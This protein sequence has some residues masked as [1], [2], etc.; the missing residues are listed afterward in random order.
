MTYLIRN[1]IKCVAITEFLEGLIHPFS[2]YDNLNLYLV[3][4]NQK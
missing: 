3:F 1:T 2:G 4:E